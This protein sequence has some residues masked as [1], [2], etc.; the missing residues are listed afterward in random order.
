MS[1]EFPEISSHVEQGM[2]SELE[3]KPDTSMSA[4]GAA[5]APASS[6][7]VATQQDEA[8]MLLIRR[9]CEGEKE[10][11]YQLVSPYQK[12]VSL[13]SLSMLKNEHDA[14]EV[15]QEALFRAFKALGQ[16]RGDCRFSTWLIQIAINEARQRLRRNK[17]N[18]EQSLDAGQESD[19]GDYMP[20]DLADWRE[21]PSECLQRKELREALRRAIGNLKPHYREVVLLRDVDQRSVAETARILDISEA[22]VKTRLLRARLQ[23]RDALSPGYDGAWSTGRTA[24]KRVRAF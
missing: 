23:L 19:E 8:E 2:A 17:R 6:P 20:M 18:A 13:T 14:E 10:L 11:F 22:T 1:G 9:I 3:S 24:Y 4:A 12:M 21:I 16:F 5:P 7:P 15:A